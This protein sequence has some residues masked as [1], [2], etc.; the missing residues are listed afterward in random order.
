MHQP[1][2]Q[3]YKKKGFAYFATLAMHAMLYLAICSGITL[4][5][6]SFSFNKGVRIR[7]S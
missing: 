7:S 6:A 4:H 5:T 3:T 1:S 2:K